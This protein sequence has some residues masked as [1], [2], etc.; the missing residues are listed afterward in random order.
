MLEKT[1]ESPLD[2]KEV[3]LV[4]PKGNQLWINHWDQWCLSWSSNTLAIWCEELTHWKRLWCWERL[5]EEEEGNRGW[6]GWMLSLIPWTWTWANSRRWWGTGRPV[7]LQPMGSQRVGHHLATEEQQQRQVIFFF[8]FLLCKLPL[9][10][11]D[12]PWAF[13]QFNN[14]TT[15]SSYL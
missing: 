10:L 15:L 1:L 11:F 3:K 13:L 2:N 12:I 14:C 6:D 8:F 7:V 9:L 4:S 5:K